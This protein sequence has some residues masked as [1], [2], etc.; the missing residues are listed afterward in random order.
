VESRRR[1][2]EELSQLLE[3]TQIRAGSDSDAVL[4]ALGTTT[5]AES[6]SAAR[7]LRRPEISLEDLMALLPPEV[8]EALRSAPE[9]IRDRIAIEARYDGYIRRQLAEIRRH[10][11]TESLTIPDGFDFSRVEGLTFEAKDKLTRSRPGTLGQASRVPG[12]SPADI[13]VL[14]V[15]LHRALRATSQQD[16]LA[17]GSVGGQAGA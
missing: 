11:A 1:Q 2:T 15:H 17:R 5:L 13:S 4:E 6:Q 12:V 8:R 3:E 9:D 16:A 10:R 7:M 14:L